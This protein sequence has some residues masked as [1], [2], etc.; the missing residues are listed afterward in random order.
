MRLLSRTLSRIAGTQLTDTT[1]GFRANGPRALH[2][3]AQHYPAEYLGDTVE[4]IVIASRAG[5]RVRQ[6]PVHMRERA[7]GQPSQ[8]PLRATLYLIRAG[9]AL[10][11]AQLRWKD[12]SIPAATQPVQGLQPAVEKESA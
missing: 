10:G 1:S 6:V 5:L 11:M 3:L 4:T 9:L 2:L 12:M 8:T 7:G